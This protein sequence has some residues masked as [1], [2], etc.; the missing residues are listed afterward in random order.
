MGDR[1]NIVVSDGQNPPVFLYSHWT[2]SDLPKILQQAL[3]RGKGRWG[4]APYLTRIIFSEMIKDDVLAETG[5][6]ISTSITD[7]E[8]NILLVDDDKRVV[9]VFHYKSW[10]D[11]FDDMEVMAEFTYKEYVE[12]NFYGFDAYS[13]TWKVDKSGRLIHEE[14]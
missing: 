6:G 11:K 12:L 2:G 7:N 3:K 10:I 14:E 4:D 8:N 13:C 5:Y 1:G 9:K